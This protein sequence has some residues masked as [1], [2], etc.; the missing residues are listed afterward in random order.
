M[1]TYSPFLSG[2]SRYLLEGIIGIRLPLFG[3]LTFGLD[4]VD[5]YDS[6]PP[7]RTKK[8]DLLIL[9]TLGWAF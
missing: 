6:S 3:S 2:D 5:N 1:T 8:N 7:E 9:S 4:L